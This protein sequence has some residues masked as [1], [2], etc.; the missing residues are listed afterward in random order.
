MVVWVFVLRIF[1]CTANSTGGS[2][3]VFRKEGYSDEVESA[4][5]QAN[6]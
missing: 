4:L 6:I 3:W 2:H 1:I 5:K